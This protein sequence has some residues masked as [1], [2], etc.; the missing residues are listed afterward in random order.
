MPDHRE[1][2]DQKISARSIV[3]KLVK[4]Q[5]KKDAQEESVIENMK[6]WENVINRISSSSD[7]QLLIKYL[8][9]HNKLFIVDNV[10]DHV[11]MIENSGAKKVYLQL[12][13]PF[14]TPEVLSIVE[15]QK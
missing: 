3:D 6:E 12:I 14:L 7:G 9:R 10:R 11:T 15:N 13:R 5:A 1:D 2:G 4:E 8:L